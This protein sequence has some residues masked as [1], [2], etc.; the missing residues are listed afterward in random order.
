MH[1]GGDIMLNRQS[2]IA[3]V[4]LTIG[5]WTGA[6]RAQ[7]LVDSFYPSG[8][9]YGTGWVTYDGPGYT[10]H[11]D[12]LQWSQPVYG[13]SYFH[14]GTWPQNVDSLAIGYYELYQ[15]GNYH[16]DFTWTNDLDPT[17][18]TAEELFKGLQG[19]SYLGQETLGTG[20][21]RFSK[22]P[23]GWPQKKADVLIGWLG[24][25][26]SPSGIY[27]KAYG[28]TYNGVYKPRLYIYY[29]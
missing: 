6:V 19:G 23:G 13:W 20:W 12:T 17:T 22:G 21:L 14:V 25:A 18:C 10:K 7:A 27:G 8:S 16:A 5:L 15:F 2:G 29:H 28:H 3:V 26:A 11:D 1:D 24:D 9:Q 4:A